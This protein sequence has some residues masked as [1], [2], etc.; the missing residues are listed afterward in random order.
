MEVRRHIPTVV[1]LDIHPALHE[2]C[3]HGRPNLLSMAVA[4][5]FYSTLTRPDPEG[6]PGLWMRDNEPR[7]KWWKTIAEDIL[8]TW[9]RQGWTDRISLRFEWFQDPRLRPGVQAEFSNYLASVLMPIVRV[10][11]LSRID[12]AFSDDETGKNT[13]QQLRAAFGRLAKHCRT[14]GNWNSAL[15]R[16][17]LWRYPWPVK[18]SIPQA[19]HITD[20]ES[21]DCLAESL[22]EGDPTQTIIWLPTSEAARPEGGWR[23]VDPEVCAHWT[24]KVI[25]YAVGKG[26]TGFGYHGSKHARNG[27]DGRPIM[28]PAGL[29]YM[30]HLNACVIRA[31]VKYGRV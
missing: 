30:D 17:P 27:P 8:A 2:V 25:D 20:Q 4:N 3:E 24:E 21:F 12:L 29:E 14:V 5:A 11:G 10:N 19:Y 1:Y 31:N 23:F 7:N 18:A 22:E 15:G 13:P 28:P 6:G 26:C 16:T 9:E